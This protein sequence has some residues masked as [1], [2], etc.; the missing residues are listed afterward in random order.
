MS[1]IIP[2][3]HSFIYQASLILKDSIGDYTEIDWLL[4]NL[5]VR[6]LQ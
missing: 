6:N 5:K 2:V 4:L 3:G 1:I